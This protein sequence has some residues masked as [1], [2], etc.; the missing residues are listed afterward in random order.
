[1]GHSVVSAWIRT[2][3][4]LKPT[5]VLGRPSVVDPGAY[6]IVLL[7]ACGCLCRA[8]SRLMEQPDTTV[9]AT[10]AQQLSDETTSVL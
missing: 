10:P 3:F 6:C 7:I 5:L 4:N 2:Y 1:V 8:Q 9:S